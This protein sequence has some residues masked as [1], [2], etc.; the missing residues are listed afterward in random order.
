[1]TGVIGRGRPR[2]APRTAAERFLPSVI[3][4]TGLDI[5]RYICSGW[6]GGFAD[7]NLLVEQFKANTAPDENGLRGVFE[8]DFRF[9]G[10]SCPASR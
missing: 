10:G 9:A 1:M 2:C 3:T 5:H 7:R 8:V 4:K 6:L